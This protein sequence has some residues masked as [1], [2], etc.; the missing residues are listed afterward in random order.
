MKKLFLVAVVGMLAMAC[1]SSTNQSQNRI[2]TNNTG[3][4]YANNTA[5][6]AAKYQIIYQE[7]EN[8]VV[9]NDNYDRITPYEEQINISSYIQSTNG[10]SKTEKPHKVMV[11]KTVVDGNGNILSSNAKAPVTDQ[12][13]LPDGAGI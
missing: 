10:R 5:N 11:E 13:T 3:R 8:Y 6:D 9:E 7:F 1:T 4:A 2:Y 12:E